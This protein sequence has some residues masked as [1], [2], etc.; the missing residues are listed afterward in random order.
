MNRIFRP[1]LG[2]HEMASVEFYHDVMESDKPDMRGRILAVTMKPCAA[3]SLD[4]METIGFQSLV[5]VAAALGSGY[6]F[7]PQ[8]IERNAFRHGG[9]QT[10]D[11]W[12]QGDVLD[13]DGGA[14][15]TLLVKHRDWSMT[16][17]AH[18]QHVIASLAMVHRTNIINPPMVLEAVYEKSN[19]Q[20]SQ[21]GLLPERNGVESRRGDGDGPEHSQR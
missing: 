13:I 8:E 3:G 6:H 11:A 7:D 5:W 2:F 9:F 17:T 20:R 15:V 4:Y 19:N 12:F 14:H 16:C 10:C 18:Y 21:L 1:S